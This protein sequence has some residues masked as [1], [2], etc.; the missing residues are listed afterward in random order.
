MLD[1][2]L[3][4]LYFA[5]VT[6]VEQTTT[7]D[8]GSGVSIL[9]FKGGGFD[10]GGI[11]LACPLPTVGSFSRDPAEAILK[12]GHPLDVARL[13]D[14][15][16]KIWSLSELDPSS[17]SR[18][19]SLLAYRP[20]PVS[21]SL[22]SLFDDGPCSCGT[23]LVF[24]PREP[25]PR[26]TTFGLAM[27]SIRLSS[28]PSQGPSKPV[29]DLV[30]AR[31]PG[32][33]ISTLRTL[34]DLTDGGIIEPLDI[35]PSRGS[36]NFSPAFIDGIFG[37]HAPVT[38]LPPEWILR[39]PSGMS[40]PLGTWHRALSAISSATD[41]LLSAA[42]ELWKSLPTAMPPD[43]VRLLA[44]DGSP[45]DVT[46]VI[47][48]ALPPG[49]EDSDSIL[50]K[51]LESALSPEVPISKSEV[52]GSIIGLSRPRSEEA[53]QE[54]QGDFFSSTGVAP[55]LCSSIPRCLEMGPSLHDV[56][57]DPEGTARH[58]GESYLQLILALGNED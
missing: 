15:M 40:I 46:L 51:Y 53:G 6:V 34:C 3:S 23:A 31:I 56:H 10:P 14:L 4:Y 35:L 11:A 25:R 47:S 37:L 54:H 19:V 16:A 29:S 2:I 30:S 49:P 58:L 7:D 21:R 44:L 13:V 41:R 32:A 36:D 26:P 9:G 42:S 20:D 52:N 43:P 12:G 48:V 57:E 45:D 39:D 55:W 22:R 28:K 24:S 33:P 18:P 1:R 27:C 38:D 50:V 8:F 5:D 17:M